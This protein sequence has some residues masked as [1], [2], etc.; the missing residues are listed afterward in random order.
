M[1][2]VLTS[3]PWPSSWWTSA[4][5]FSRVASRMTVCDAYYLVILGRRPRIQRIAQRATSHT[6]DRRAASPPITML[7]A[8]SPPA[9]YGCKVVLRTI[10]WILAPSLRD[11]A[12]MTSESRAA[13]LRNLKQAGGSA[14]RNIVCVAPVAPRAFV[15]FVV[16]L[17]PHDG[18][19]A[20]CARMTVCY[21]RLRKHSQRAASPPAFYVC[22][23]RCFGTLLFR[24]PAAWARLLNG[25]VCVGGCGGFGVLRFA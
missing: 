17:R 4:L 21:A 3:L 7:Q 13:R 22:V 10:C 2:R 9:F 15:T 16:A 12:R 20:L 18:F 11:C 23:P 8:A 14:A 1:A 5:S 6:Q 19:S 24:C 25:W